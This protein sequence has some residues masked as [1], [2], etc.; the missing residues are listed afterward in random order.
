MRAGW[1]VL[2][3][4]LWLPLAAM[5]QDAAGP[6]GPAP[7]S[8][9]VINQ[10]AL[11]EQSAFGRNAQAR[12]EAASKALV[13]ENREIEAA[14]EAEERDLTERRG[15]LPSDTFRAE[16][17][18]FNVKVEGIRKAQDAKSRAITRGRDE[19]RQKFLQAAAP[20]LAQLLRE[21]GAVV[22]LDQSQV[23]LSLDR[24]DITA[25]AVQRLDAEIG[26]GDLSGSAPAPAP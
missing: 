10:D 12:L 25:E 3:G 24:I 22:V 13:A 26:T 4:A 6:V 18:A 5:A 9:L 19:D 14:L 17:E 7:P 1:R 11:F 8:I 16:S 15:T 23:V 2:I 20:I 21:H